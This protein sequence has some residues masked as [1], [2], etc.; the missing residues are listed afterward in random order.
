MKAKKKNREIQLRNNPEDKRTF[1][2]RWEF[3]DADGNVV[4]KYY[5]A[6]DGTTEEEANRIADKIGKVFEII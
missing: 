2:I 4:F 3:I 5:S 1:L 6:P